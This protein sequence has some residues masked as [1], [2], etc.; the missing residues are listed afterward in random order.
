MKAFYESAIALVTPK[1]AAVTGFAILAAFAAVLPAG[2]CPVCGP[3]DPDSVTT[4]IPANPC[5]GELIFITTDT[6]YYTLRSCDGG[7]PNYDSQIVTTTEYRIAGPGDAAN[8]PNPPPTPP[9]PPCPNADGCPPPC[10]DCPC[11]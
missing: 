4:T 5:P 1:H 8:C 7:V 2:G 11:D 9:P 10:P 3:R 6:T